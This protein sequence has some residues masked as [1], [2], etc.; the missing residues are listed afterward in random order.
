L[1]DFRFESRVSKESN[2]RN[3][4]GEGETQLTVSLLH[5]VVFPLL[6]T[7]ES[8]IKDLTFQASFTLLI[9]KG[10]PINHYIL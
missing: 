1:G 5:K 6:L 7:P 3:P 4:V 8:Q 10:R 9:Q 2:S